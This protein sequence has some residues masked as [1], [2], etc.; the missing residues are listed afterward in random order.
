MVANSA[1][2][3][4]AENGPSPAPRI[5]STR[6]AGVASTVA[7]TSGIACHISRLKALRRSGRS[8]VSVATGPSMAS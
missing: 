2:S 7:T 3:A 6:T 8:M 1:M 4:P 5:T